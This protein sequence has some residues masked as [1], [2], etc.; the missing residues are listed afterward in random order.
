M[1]AIVK[2]KLSQDMTF[3]YC[4]V[5]SHWGCSSSSGKKLPPSPAKGS[6]LKIFIWDLYLGPGPLLDH[7]TL[8]LICFLHLLLGPG[9]K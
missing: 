9:Q 8:G 1:L 2:L 6:D 4:Y 5:Q 3:E 7:W